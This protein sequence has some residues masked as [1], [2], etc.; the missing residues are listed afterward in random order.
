MQAVST[1]HHYWQKLHSPA[2]A[3][4]DAVAVA[5][6]RIKPGEHPPS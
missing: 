4:A 1:Q 5:Q 6:H 3:V 2:W